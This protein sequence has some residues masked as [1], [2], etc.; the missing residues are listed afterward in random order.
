M[1][2]CGLNETK[3]DNYCKDMSLDV[4]NCDG[5]S[6][7]YK[8]LQYYVQIW[9]EPSFFFLLVSIF[10]KLAHCCAGFSLIFTKQTQS[11][12]QGIYVLR[13]PLLV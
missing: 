9:S 10:F 8:A 13:L 12:T 2:M 4:G 7:L 5:L 6:S 11:K 1:N 3:K